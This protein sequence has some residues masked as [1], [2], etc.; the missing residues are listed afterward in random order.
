MFLIFFLNKDETKWF[1][2]WNIV[3]FIFKKSL[4]SLGDI[5]LL[6]AVCALTLTAANILLE[7]SP[8]GFGGLSA[9]DDCWGFRHQVL[10]HG[11]HAGK[12]NLA[13]T[14][15]A[16]SNN[17][18]AIVDVKC[19]KLVCANITLDVNRLIT[20]S[21]AAVLDSPVVVASPEERNRS[22]RHQFSKHVEG[23][24][25]ALIES[26]IPVL[27]SNTLAV[28]PVRVWGN[29]SSSEDIF[30]ARLQERIAGDTSVT[31]HIDSDVGEEFS[32]W[33]HAFSKDNEV[34][35]NCSAWNQ[36]DA[37]DLSIW[38][39]I[40]WSNVFFSQNFYTSISVILG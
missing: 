5:F 28:D 37:V 31:L 9:T 39:A 24:E 19:R 33:S 17:L 12:E 14:N 36:L 2:V 20:S 15:G 27:S 35:V 11:F 8:D 30:V 21:I 25:G 16:N 34:D 23:C 32:C 22:V 38:G 10:L 7:L 26:Y 29:I 1:S 13:H 6:A 18:V 40:N 4:I 3:H